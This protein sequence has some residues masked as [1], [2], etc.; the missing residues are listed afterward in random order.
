MAVSRR[1]QRVQQL[2][3]PFGVTWFATG[4]DRV[5]HDPH[6]VGDPLH[7]IGGA[8]QLI[9]AGPPLRGCHHVIEARV[10]DSGGKPLAL[11]AAGGPVR[12]IGVAHCHL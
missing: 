2:L 11:Q 10:V 4:N 7:D 1:R 5:R 9:I 12:M 3:Q 8:R 6:L